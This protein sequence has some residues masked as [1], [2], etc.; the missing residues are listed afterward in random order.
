[1][2]YLVP[3]VVLAALAGVAYWKKAVILAWLKSKFE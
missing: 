2:D 3:L 1:M